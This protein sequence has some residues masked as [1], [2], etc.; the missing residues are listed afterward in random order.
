MLSIAHTHIIRYVVILSISYH[1]FRRN[2]ATNDRSAPMKY[3][4]E[5]LSGCIDSD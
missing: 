1:L 4:D 2:F 5:G 3:C